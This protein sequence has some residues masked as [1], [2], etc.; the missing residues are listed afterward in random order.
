MLRVQRGRDAGSNPDLQ[1]LII[2]PDSHPLD[3]LQPSRMQGR[4][5]H[6]VVHGREIAVNTFNEVFLHR[7]C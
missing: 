4:S 2:G 3:S 6:D 5:I 7:R 1:N